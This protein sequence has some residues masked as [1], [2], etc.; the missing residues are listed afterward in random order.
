VITTVTTLVAGVGFVLLA[1]LDELKELGEIDE[2]VNIELEIWLTVVITVL[3]IV[4][5]ASVI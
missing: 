4:G 2:L 5:P 1:D 3:V